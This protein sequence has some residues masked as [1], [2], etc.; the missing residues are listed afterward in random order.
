MA[1]IVVAALVGG[2]FCAAAGQLLFAGGAR[3]RT[4]LLSFIN[5]SIMA[6]LAL[7]GVST[8]FWIYSLSRAPLLQVY[9]FTVLTFVLIYL[10]AVLVLGEQPTIPGLAGVTLVLGGLYLLS[11]R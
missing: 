11:L 4:D 3:G 9:P 6:G 7:Y 5:P 2:A 10:V 8:A 1:P